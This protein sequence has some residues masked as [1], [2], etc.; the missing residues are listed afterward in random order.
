MPNITMGNAMKH[1]TIVAIVLAAWASSA[2]ADTPP[3]RVINSLTYDAASNAITSTVSGGKRGLDANVSNSVSAP[4][5][6]S[7]IVSGAAIDPRQIRA[8]TTSDQVGAAQVGSWNIVNVSGTVSLPTNA[9]QET[10]GNLAASASTLATINGKITSFDLDTG[11]GVQN[12]Q[13]A[14]LRFSASGGSVEAGTSANPLR[15]DPTGATTQPVSAASLPLPSGAS[16]AALQ[17]SGNASLSSIDGKLNNTTGGAIKTDGSAFTQPISAASLPLPSGASTS[18]NQGTGN[19]TLSNIN[20]KLFVNGTADAAKVDGSSFTQPISGTVTVSGTVAATQSGAWAVRTQDG[21]GNA[22]TS[23][24][25]GSQRVLDVGVNVAGVLIDPRSI[26]NLAS[27]SDSI[28]AVQSGTWNVGNITGT[29]TLPTGAATASL[30]T[31]GNATLTSIDGKTLTAGQKAMAGSYPIVIASD[32][33]PIPI[34]GSIS[35]SSASVGAIAGNV[36]TSGDFI[37][38][39]DS[40]GKLQGFLIGGGGSLQVAGEGVAG[41]PAGGVI[42]VQGVAGGTAQPVSQSGAFNITNISGTVSLPTGASTSSLQTTGNS[43]LSSIDTKTPALV[44]GRVPVDGSGVTQPVSG[45]VTANAGTGTF[46]ISAAS[47]PLPAGAATAAKQPALGTAGTASSDVITVQ[48]IASMVALKVDASATTQPVSGT[49][50]AN[51]GGAPWSV[52]GSGSAGTAATGVLTVQGI[53]SM[54][55]LKVDG[56]AVTQPV[57]G[58]VTAN[59]GGSWNITNVSGTVSLPTGASTSALQTSGNSSLS[60]IDTKTPALVSGRVP[61]DGSGVTQPVSGTVTANAGTGTFAIS[62]AALPLPTGASTAAKQPAIG[63]A[64]TPS[65]DVLTVQGAASM[66]ALKVDGS[67]VTQPVSGTVSANQAGTW[68]INNISGTVSLPTGAATASAQTTM[69]ASLS[70]IDGKTA[71]LVSGRVPVDGS[72]VTQ[73]ISAA[74]LPLP[75]GAATS[76]SQTTMNASLSSIDGKTPALGQTTQALGQPIVQPGDLTSTT[77]SITIQ[78]T[79]STSTVQGNNQTVLSGSATAGSTFAIATQSYNAVVAKVS[80]TWTGSVQLEQSSDGGSTWIG[81][82]THQVGGSIFILAYTANVQIE[83]NLAG[84]TNVRVRA[85]SA[86]TGTVSVQ[87]VLSYNATGITFVNNAVRITD[88][89]NS[90]VA[91]PLT[92]LAASTAAAT[93]NTSAVVALSPNSPLPPGTNAIG[94]V[95]LSDG[96]NT[97]AVTSALAVHTVQD[98]GYK[99]TYS[100]GAV[101]ITPAATATDVFVIS[102]SAS[103]TVRVTRISASCTSTAGLT[104]NAAIIKRSSADTG[105]TSAAVTAAP[106]DSADAAATASVLSYTANPTGLGTAVGNVRTFKLFSPTATTFQTFQEMLFGNASGKAVVL[107]GVAQQLAVNLSATTVTG[108]SCDYYA[109]WTE[110]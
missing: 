73:P 11:A 97:A 36:P 29:V 50:T 55:A 1:Q 3:A 83:A 16:T 22:I 54:V 53:A 30:Q 33:S 40:A 60:S 66:T 14:N 39:K 86:I 64:G 4:A 13:G 48:G 75:A 32:Q 19:T 58:T 71:T 49:V 68:N 44:S 28:S 82:P 43:S 46:A 2:L 106:L 76:A 102:G 89:A 6:A 91:T 93:G 51:Q 27:G 7:I 38:G 78:D 5:N 31:S 85:P 95:Q 77:G 62:A 67:A 42:S 57:S 63:T 69:N 45:S 98:D 21:A 17:T 84:K 23:Q 37:A 79:G 110:E 15:F 12:V 108:G 18:A 101:A 109:E 52:T 61:V 105:G 35:V 26:R 25:S 59:Q 24:V 74:A 103:K 100:A 90:S 34:T 72:A 65:A 99:A 87:F 88:G 107:R 20:N 94:T 56:S 10:G 92:V 41:T 81:I 70:S 96:T 80:G 8:L 47:L 9:A 104:V